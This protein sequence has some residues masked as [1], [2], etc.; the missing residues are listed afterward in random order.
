MIEIWL[1]GAVLAV[2]VVL[3]VRLVVGDVRRHRFDAF[4]ARRWQALRTRLRE[5]WQWR[6]VRRRA[7]READEAIRRARHKAK[8]DGNV[9]RP[10]QF[11]S[12]KKPH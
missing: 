8:R 9:I 2:C 4:V 1:A 12:P 5:G 11:E 7:A 6:G 10:E 3:L